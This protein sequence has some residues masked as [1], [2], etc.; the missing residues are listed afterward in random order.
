MDG[1][2]LRVLEE[3]NKGLFTIYGERLHQVLVYGSQA[4]G[5]ASPESDVDILIILDDPVNPLLE[6]SN[7][8]RLI[9]DLS[10]RNDTVLSCLF[11][12]LSEFNNQADLFLRNVRRDAFP[13]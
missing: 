10:L 11:I 5:E 12:S 9:A 1:N 7:T 13:L 3:L 8:E 6:I 2:L 4:R